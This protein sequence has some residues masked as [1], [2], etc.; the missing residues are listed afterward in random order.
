MKMTELKDLLRQRGLADKGRKK[1]D[2][3]D[4]LLADDNADTDSV[5]AKN[6]RHGTPMGV[7]RVIE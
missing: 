1:A 3:V 4:R 7:A 2:L 5:R 6:R